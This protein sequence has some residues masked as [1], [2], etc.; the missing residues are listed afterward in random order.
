MKKLLKSSI[1]LAIMAVFIFA[2]TGCAGNKLVATKTKEESAFGKYEEKIEIKFKNKIASEIKTTLV[3]KDEDTAKKVVELYE[4][5]GEADDMQRKGKK[6]ITKVDV[7][8]YADSEDVD[9]EKLTKE[10]LKKQY[11]EDGYKVK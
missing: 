10:Y 3:F 2:L 7:S 4:K 5:Y 1:L 8:K 11:E 6:V 9:K